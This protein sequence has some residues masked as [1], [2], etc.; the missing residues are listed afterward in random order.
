MEFDSRR[1]IDHIYRSKI[2]QKEGLDERIL[3]QMTERSYS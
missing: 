1:Q 3:K 2:F